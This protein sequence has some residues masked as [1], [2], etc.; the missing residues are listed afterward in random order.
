MITTLKDIKKRMLDYVSTFSAGRPDATEQKIVEWAQAH[1][2]AADQVLKAAQILKKTE[3]DSEYVTANLNDP[4][5]FINLKGHLQKLSN[6]TKEFEALVKSGKI[7]RTKEGRIG[8]QT[9]ELG[10]VSYA[11]KSLLEAQVA[12]VDAAVASKGEE[13]TQKQWEGFRGNLF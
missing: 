2:N 1:A 10:L 4:N 8:G 6:A 11:V 13:S 3:L 12:K 7:F 5:V 9:M